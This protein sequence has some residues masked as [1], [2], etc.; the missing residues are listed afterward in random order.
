[1]CP[2]GAYPDAGSAHLCLTDQCDANG[3]KRKLQPR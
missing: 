2:K 3:Q 1:V